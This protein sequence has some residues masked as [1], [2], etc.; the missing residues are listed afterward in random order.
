MIENEILSSEHSD[1]LQTHIFTLPPEAGSKFF[2]PEYIFFVFILL[3]TKK[4]LF[5]LLHITFANFKYL[6]SRLL[7][8]VTR[9]LIIRHALS[10]NSILINT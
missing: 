6:T 3:I 2:F 10:L 5:P 9:T 7:I 1:C 4:C 8:T